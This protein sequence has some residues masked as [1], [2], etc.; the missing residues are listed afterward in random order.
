MILILAWRN[1]WRNKVRSIIIIGSV[2]LGVLAGLFILALYADMIRS[3]IRTIIEDEVS[4]LQIHH[5]EFKK[6][7]K[8]EYLLTNSAQLLSALEQIDE[9]AAVSPRVV[10]QGMLATAT[11]SSGVEIRGVMPAEEDRV[12]RLSTKIVE[13]GYFPG[14]RKNELLVGRKLAEK[15]GLKLQDKVV[16][17]F[18]DKD[19]TIT[20]GAFRITGIYQSSNSSLDERLV[21]VRLPDIAGLLNVGDDYHEIAIVLKEDRFLDP[22]YLKLQAAYP[23]WLTETWKQIAPETEFLTAVT[24]QF[25]YI[26]MIIIMLALAFGIVN[27]MLMA[28]LERIKETGMMVALGMSKPRLFLLVLL[29]TIFLTLLGTPIGIFLTWVLT[30]YLSKEGIDVSEF[31]GSTMAGYGFKQVIYPHFPARQIGQMIAIVAGTAILSS[32]LPAIRALRMEP[33]DALRK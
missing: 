6:D 21:Y 31:S 25:T 5:P 1:I 26:I 4:H 13:G 23:Q 9:V 32:I 7:Y 29:E 15:K 16:L 24:N 14:K 12:S 3:R 27:T 20:S 10:A 22:V 11:G 17:T 33:A 8:A 19:K 18:A 30:A 2:A 28:I